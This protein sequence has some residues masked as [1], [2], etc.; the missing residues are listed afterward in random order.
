MSQKKWFVPASPI[1]AAKTYATAAQVHRSY[2]QKCPLV[3]LV[4]LLSRARHAGG[5]T[6]RGADGAARRGRTGRASAGRTAP[7]REGKTGGGAHWRAEP[8]GVQRQRTERCERCKYS[9]LRMRLKEKR[10]PRSILLEG[11]GKTTKKKK[12]WEEEEKK[13]RGNINGKE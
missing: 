1:S 6:G 9:W 4:G 8:I 7:G 10:G 5:G 2:S 11:P 13:K 3:P 12:A